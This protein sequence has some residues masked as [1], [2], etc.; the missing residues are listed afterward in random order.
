MRHRIVAGFAGALAVG[1]VVGVSAGPAKASLMTY[2]PNG[3][4]STK[5]FT[6]EVKFDQ[7]VHNNGQ[8]G[9]DV[10]LRNGEEFAGPSSNFSWPASGTTFDWS[11]TY[12]GNTASFVFGGLP[13]LNLDVNPDGNWNAFRLDL[14]SVDSDR[15]DSA[16]VLV[17]I[18][19]VNGVALGAPVDNSASLVENTVV[20]Y[21]FN[22]FETL[23]SLTGTMRFD[24]VVADLETGSPNSRLRFNIK[25]LSTT[26]LPEPASLAL[27]TLGLVG[28]AAATRRSRTLRQRR[29]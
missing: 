12:D 21:K 16:S 1:I 7:N 9:H 11:L 27:F 8:R 18:T 29:A 17:S 10:F 3:V 15:F 22:D 2:D 24:Y 19:D 4:S 20:D 26:E 23:T 6:T 25:A 28:L 5:L 13:A 14:A